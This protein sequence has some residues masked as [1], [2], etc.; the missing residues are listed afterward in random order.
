[1]GLKLVP[2]LRRAILSK[3]NGFAYGVVATGNDA[4][5]KSMG[6]PKGRRSFRGI[7]NA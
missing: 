2:A 7:H 5:Y 3:F 1:M 4:N 6:H